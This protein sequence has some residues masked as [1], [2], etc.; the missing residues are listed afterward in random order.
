MKALLFLCVLFAA[1]SRY[2][3][4][5]MPE[6]REVQDCLGS[7]FSSNTLEWSPDR[8]KRYPYGF[9]IDGPEPIDGHFIIGQDSIRGIWWVN[10]DTLNFR[11][12]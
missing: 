2:Y 4:V 3:V 1:C 11:K 9:I 10:R 6:Q 7:G 5:I 8:E 12:E